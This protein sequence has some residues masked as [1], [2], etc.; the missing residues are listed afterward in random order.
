[1]RT[2]RPGL[3]FAAAQQGGVINGDS[4]DVVTFAWAADPL[5]DYSGNL[6]CDSFPPNGGNTLRWCNKR[7]QHAMN[8]LVEEYDPAQRKADLE[9][10]MREVRNDAPMIVLSIRVDMFA[11]NRDLTNY[12]PNSLTIFDNMMDVD[13]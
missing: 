9:V 5:G 13:I 1:V 12:H 7:A 2:V 11:Y 8:A 4:W 3:M 10:V 6:G